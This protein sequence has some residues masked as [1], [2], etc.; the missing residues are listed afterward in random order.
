MNYIDLR[1]RKRRKATRK[2][3]MSHNALFLCNVKS[4]IVPVNI[5]KACGGMGVGLHA[6]L[7]SALDG[8]GWLRLR[9][10]AL[11]AGRNADKH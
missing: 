9:P 11:P 3:E 5:M 2:Q 4:V 6:F 7:T 1:Q 10:G 8:V